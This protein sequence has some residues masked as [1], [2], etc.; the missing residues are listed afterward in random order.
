MRF[1]RK[2]GRVI[3]IRDSGAPISSIKK[4]PPV[5]KLGVGK[6]ALIGAATG[7]AARASMAFGEA[8]ATGHALVRPK[9]FG[10]AAALGAGVGALIGSFS[11]KAAPERRRSM[12]NPKLRT[13]FVKRFGGSP[14]YK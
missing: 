8:A 3:P 6:G 7:I 14:K 5:E 9:A 13:Q 2:G 4:Y 11:S 10:V 12:K 1:I